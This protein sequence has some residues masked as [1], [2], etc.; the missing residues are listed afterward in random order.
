MATKKNEAKKSVQT[1]LDTKPA[2]PVETAKVV[3]PAAVEPTEQ[4][5]EVAAATVEPAGD[6]PVSAGEE[7]A[8]RP[9]A[10]IDQ[11]HEPPMGYDGFTED[12]LI[13]PR[14]SIVQKSS[15][16]VDKGFTVGTFRS[17]ISDESEEEM[18][19]TAIL[20]KKGMVHFVKPYQKGQKPD[21]RSN[22]A[23]TPSPQVEKPYNAVCHKLVRRRL[24]A[25]CPEAAWTKDEKTGK[26]IPPACNICFNVVM[27]REDT[28]SPFFMSFR[29]SG[30]R[31]I[32]AFISNLWSMRR[33]LFSASFKLATELV[34]NT[35]G[36]FYVPTLTEIETHSEES[37][38]NLVEI[39]KGM[40][41]MNL[42]ESFDDERNQTDDGG[43]DEVDT[44]FEPSDLENEK[45]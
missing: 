23:M 28:G 9:A 30:L 2:R 40:Q 31:P 13:I 10:A 22:D 45:F 44:S 29:S 11:Y 21:C 6:E 14:F 27:R 26:S 16:A 15:E 34:S 25:V 38:P 24:V 41:M 19:C 39:Y 42:D 20:Y 33:D 1:T 4:P 36:T 37:V 12:D 35:H 7:L 17:N 43:I 18:R 8:T 3:E 32:R 5:S